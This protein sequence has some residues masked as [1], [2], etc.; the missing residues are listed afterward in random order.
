VIG[1][2]TVGGGEAITAKM[3]NAAKIVPVVRIVSPFRSPSR[4][5]PG[6]QR[7]VCPIAICFQI[8]SENRIVL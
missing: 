3:N 4:C 6:L 8:R 1:A 2:A 5:G 7:S